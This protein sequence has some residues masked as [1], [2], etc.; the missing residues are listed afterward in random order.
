MDRERFLLISLSPQAKA[1]A[2]RMCPHRPH[3]LLPLALR[4]VPPGE[5]DWRWQFWRYLPRCGTGMA[6]VAGRALSRPWP[7]SLQQEQ[8]QEQLQQRL[9]KHWAFVLVPLL[10]SGSWACASDD[11]P[12][13]FLAC[14]ARPNRPARPLPLLTLSS[15]SPPLCQPALAQ[16][17]HSYLQ[18]PLWLAAWAPP[19]SGSPRCWEALLQTASKIQHSG[20]VSPA[21]PH[22]PQQTQLTTFSFGTA[23]MRSSCRQLCPHT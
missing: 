22:T 12:F 21:P 23:L 19:G 18:V 6:F 11:M 1:L 3:A 4:Q 17:A 15:S 9:Q 20:P 10:A 14:H 13:S 7:D 16:P 2:P 8:Q 5:T